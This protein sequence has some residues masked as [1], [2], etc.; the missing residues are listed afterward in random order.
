MRGLSRRKFV[1]IDQAD[2]IVINNFLFEFI[3]TWIKPFTISDLCFNLKTGIDVPYH[4]IK[5][6]IKNKFYMNYKRTNSRPKCYANWATFAGRCLFSIKF[7]S[8]FKE[9]NLIVNIDEWSIGRSCKCNY[10]WGPKGSNI[11]CHNINVVGNIYSYLAI[12]SNWCCF[13]LT[14]QDNINSN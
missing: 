9:N 14:T 6:I 12:C 2:E 13:I 7:A 3:K 5:E 11:E 8:I 4:K 10:S 1:E